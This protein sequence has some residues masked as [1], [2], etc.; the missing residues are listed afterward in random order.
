MQGT[1]YATF[2][3][4]HH[5]C[6]CVAGSIRAAVTLLTYSAPRT[7]PGPRRWPTRSATT[8]Q[9]TDILQDIRRGPCRDRARS[10]PAEDFKRFGTEL[11]PNGSGGP[12]A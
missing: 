12:S 11:R 1:G 9:L 6:R 3:D 10:L 4:L 7:W 8:L 2:D 5:Y